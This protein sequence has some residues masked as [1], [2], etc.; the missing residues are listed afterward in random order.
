[1]KKIVSILLALTMIL[2]TLVFS[3]SANNDETQS[4]DL[5]ISNGS[6]FKWGDTIKFEITITNNTD[7]RIANV[8]IVSEPKGMS[9]YFQKTEDSSKAI[10]YITPGATRTV[11]VI[12]SSTKISDF[13]SF[14]RAI[15]SFFKQL[16]SKLSR[17]YSYVKTLKVGMS[18]VSFGIDVDYE[19]S[20]EV[21]TGNI[22]LDDPDPD[23]EIYSFNTDTYDILI[24]QTK[25]VVFTSEIFSN[26]NLDDISV[27][28][29]D[30]NNAVIGIMNDK[31]VSGDA[32]ANDGIYT[33]ST[34]L[35]SD[36]VCNKSFHSTAKGITSDSVLIGF[37]K[38]FTD[39][40]IDNYL[41]ILDKIETAANPY[42]DKDGNVLDGKEND[43]INTI[44][45][46]LQQQKN[47]GKVVSFNYNNNTFEINLKNNFSFDYML[48][49]KDTESG[50][51]TCNIATFQSFRGQWT[52]QSLNDGSDNLTDGSAQ[53]IAN[54]FDEY[55]FST[56]LDNT[57]VTISSMKNLADNKVIIINTH[58]GYSETY[59]SLIALGETQNT[60]QT[61]NYSADISEGRI[62]PVSAANKNVYAITGGF[63]SKYCGA[64]D[65]TIVYLG[66][67]DTCKD[68]LDNKNNTYELAQSF[69]NKGA[70]AVLGTNETVDADY[71]YEFGTSLFQHLTQKD[72]SN[73]YTLLESFNYA[74]AVAGTSDPDGTSFD[75]YPLN[76][77]KSQNYR[78]H[79][80]EKGSISGV[81]KDASTSS[82]VSNALIR[83]YK[84]D[85][86]IA[87][88]RTNSS[89]AY[90]LSV[91]S[92]N[93]I[94]KV[95]AG[96][97][98]SV[99]MAVTVRTNTTTY[100]ETF[101]LISN[102][103]SWGY[104][105]GNTI[106]A[107]TGQLLSNVKI[108]IRNSWNNYEGKILKTITSNENGY[109]EVELPAG[110]Y[111][112]ECYKDGYI[113]TYKNV[114]IFVYD[115]AAQNISI[116]PELE[117]GYYRVVL[118]WGTNPSDLDSHLFGRT[119]DYS[120][121]VYYSDENGYGLN[122][123]V[124]ANLDVD[125][126]TSYGP[127]TTTF[128]AASDGQY[129]FYIDWYSGSG[130]WANSGGK[131]EVYNGA[132]LINTYYV[133]NVSNNSGSWKVFSINNGIYTDYNMISSDIY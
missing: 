88:T 133:P 1:M 90:N 84:D 33:L 28:V 57:S 49:K 48:M 76:N 52:D 71:D 35:K 106:N 47:A 74:E 14:F 75:I 104:A 15:I 50:V 73:Y 67:C 29:V 59:G 119:N 98:K 107:I 11:E 102:G 41:F 46:V 10:E 79:E 115:F 131:V 127:E 118:T 109:Y 18:N 129:D 91:P 55:Y 21:N 32:I 27:S 66:A 5:S 8:N 83:I 9:K 126:T 38:N 22:N 37:Y 116:A 6:V 128:Y 24:G 93:Y 72:N 124:V 108:N 63:I 85:E 60:N 105:N 64:M 82:A 31:G 53:L 78:L 7:S 86:L 34:S 96:S 3:V 30:E 95:S 17:S 132:Y 100:N 44:K 110:L 89:G 122:N 25:N 42:L 2:S 62:R 87:S 58:G 111:T 113:T 39:N 114:L 120:Y 97:Y 13:Q 70:T 51:G 23:V 77:T 69:I 20:S 99:K 92:G 36:T 40:D 125:D 80:L 68:M 12:Y 26:I 103:L 19:E 56:N 45:N 4:V 43:V 61:K 101:L 130:T 121:H 65:N 81:I 112:F 123:T 54:T 94:V 117:E 16:F